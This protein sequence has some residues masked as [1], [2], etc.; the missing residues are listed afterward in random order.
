MADIV[1]EDFKKVE[2]VVGKVLEVEE[3][4]GADKLF[5]VTV[6][7]GAEVRK[8]VAGIKPWYQMEELKG[9]SVIVV[10]NLAPRT[11]RGVESKGMLLASR[12]GETLSIVTLDREL[13]PGSPVS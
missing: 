5:L 3:V 13:P 8:V 1:I 10:A 6:D 7:L 9:K 11:I 4:A 12:S 2:L